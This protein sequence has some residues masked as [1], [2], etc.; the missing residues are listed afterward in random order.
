MNIR[1]MQEG[2]GSYDW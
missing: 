2:T 1:V